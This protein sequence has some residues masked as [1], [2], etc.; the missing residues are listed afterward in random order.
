[1]SIWEWASDVSEGKCKRFLENDD[2]D[3]DL[4]YWQRLA[5]CWDNLYVCVFVVSNWLPH[6]IL[7]AHPHLSLC[8]SLCFSLYFPLSLSLCFSLSASLSLSFSAAFNQL[9]PIRKLIKHSP[10]HL[11]VT[12]QALFLSF[13]PLSFCISF[14]Y[15]VSLSSLKMKEVRSRNEHTN[16]HLPITLIHRCSDPC[17]DSNPP[18]LLSVTSSRGQLEVPR[19]LPQQRGP[20]P[21]V[22]STIQSQIPHQAVPTALRKV[23]WLASGVT[24]PV[25][26]A[27]L[28]M[29][30]LAT[31]YLRNWTSSRQ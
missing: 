22:V 20:L 3:T 6:C 30:P 4:L 5:V 24:S 8:V 13:S 1:M 9:W 26:L 15:L 16:T 19:D 28:S 27:T 25:T 2:I 11:S 31:L 17:S 10:F 14:L 21:E 18:P 12:P 23:T 29:C 7:H